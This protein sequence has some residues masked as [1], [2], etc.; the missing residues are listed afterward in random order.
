VYVR[1]T[2]PPGME[3]SPI[4]LESVGTLSWKRSKKSQVVQLAS[5]AIE[6]GLYLMTMPGRSRRRQEES[7]DRKSGG[8][9]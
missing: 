1:S 5:G 8:R 4:R 6:Y 7:W 3:G 2:L 9:G